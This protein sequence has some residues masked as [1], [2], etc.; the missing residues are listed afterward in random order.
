MAEKIKTNGL[1]KAISNPFSDHP[2]ESRIIMIETNRGMMSIPV[3][4]PHEYSLNEKI[5]ISITLKRDPK[6][7]G[8]V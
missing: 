8:D 5:N 7:R 4:D 1:V 6:E 2:L 3:E